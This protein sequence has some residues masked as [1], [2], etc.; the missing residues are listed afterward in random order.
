MPC[1][2]SKLSPES[3][4]TVVPP[5]FG[6]PSFLCSDF[7]AATQFTGGRQWRASDT[8]LNIMS[9]MKMKWSWKRYPHTRFKK[10][11]YELFNSQSYLIGRNFGRES[12]NHKSLEAALSSQYDDAFPKASAMCHCQRWTPSLI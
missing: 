5:N 10:R 4:A 8:V 11:W 6:Y 9:A 3:S 7:I 1:S 12:V 2:Q